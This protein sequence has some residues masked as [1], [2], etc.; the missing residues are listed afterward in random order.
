MQE[1]TALDTV[2]VQMPVNK[3][4]PVYKQAYEYA[5]KEVFADWEDDIP[6]EGGQ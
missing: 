4:L 2:A 6:A 5:K 1:K 3:T